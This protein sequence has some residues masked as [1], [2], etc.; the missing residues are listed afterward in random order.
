MIWVSKVKQLAWIFDFFDVFFEIGCF[1]RGECHILIH[2]FANIIRYIKIM[3]KLLFFSSLIFCSELFSCG[4][5]QDTEERITRTK[6]DPRS[7]SMLIQELSFSDLKNMILNDSLRFLTTPEEFIKGNE[8]YIKD[9]NKKNYLLKKKKL[10]SLISSLQIIDSLGFLAIEFGVKKQVNQ[11]K[12]TYNNFNISIGGRSKDS[13]KIANS[14]ISI[15]GN[16]DVRENS[17]F[18][19]L[20][21]KLFT[22]KI[23]GYEISY[24]G[25]IYPLKDA[26]KWVDEIDK[27]KNQVYLTPSLD[28]DNAGK[29]FTSVI[30]SVEKLDKK[31]IIRM[32]SLLFR[33]PYSTYGDKGTNCCQ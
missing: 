12:T 4:N 26:R 15:N 16:Y 17:Y 21:I 31:K 28:F 10:D 23:E 9:Y 22:A 6:T 30:F 2:K 27:N 14:F 7:K 32:P 19:E 1:S 25:V 3:K 13:T 29:G 5:N 11:N 33:D 18:R 20:Y 24:G 8:F